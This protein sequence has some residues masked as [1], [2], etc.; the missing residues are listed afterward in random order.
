MYNKMYYERNKNKIKARMTKRIQCENCGMY[1]SQCHMKGHMRSKRCS[2]FK[3]NHKSF[4]DEIN[5]T[6]E[7]INNEFLNF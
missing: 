1:I 7:F 4:E 2:N 3:T 6:L 5:K